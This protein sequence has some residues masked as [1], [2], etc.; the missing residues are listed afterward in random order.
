MTFTE[1]VLK[2]AFIVEPELRADERGF[3]ARAWCQHEFHASGLNPRL[4]QCSISFNRKRGTLRG[5][6]YQAQPYAEAKLVRCV[7]GAILDVIVDLRPD[8]PTYLRHVA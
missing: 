4:A 2:G 8:S 6:H 1:T 7:G 5:M 3:F